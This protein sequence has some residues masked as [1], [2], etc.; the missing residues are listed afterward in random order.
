MPLW[1]LRPRRHPL[2]QFCDRPAAPNAGLQNLQR[3]HDAIGRG[4]PVH[5]QE[6]AGTGT[7]QQPAAPLQFLQHMAVSDF[8][9]YEV[10]ARAPHRLLT[11]RGPRRMHHL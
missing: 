11:R 7:S 10:D 1:S 2:D 9:A 8:R 4:V 5:C 3:A 6:T